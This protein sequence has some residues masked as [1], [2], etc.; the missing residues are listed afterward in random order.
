MKTTNLFIALLSVGILLSSCKKDDTTPTPTPPI[1]NADASIGGISYDKF[2][3]VESGFNQNDPN[4]ATF[5][6]NGDFFRCK[7]CHAWDGLG[8]KGSYISRSAKATRPH[9]SEHNLYDFAQSSTA[10]EIFDDIKETAGRRDISYD[11]SAYDPVNNFTEGDKMPNYNQILTDAQIWN[12]VKFLKEGMF[13]VNQLYDATYTG[14]YPTGTA[15]FS[16]IGLDGNAANGNAYYTANCAVCHGVDGTNIVLEGKTYG[17]FVRTKPNEVQHK[18]KYGTLGS[19]MVGEFD[20]TLDEM[21]DLYK[22]S[23][24]TTA[25]PN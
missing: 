24:D 6:D 17:K 11:L 1:D 19:A 10:Q 4:F 5:N 13:N 16:N 21:K 9:V 22:A 3:S 20:I 8:N 25:F 18:V 12:I 23:S 2:W 7:Q 14:T 15:T